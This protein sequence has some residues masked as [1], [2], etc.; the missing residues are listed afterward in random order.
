[1]KNLKNVFSKVMA[2]LLCGVM[3]LGL[4]PGSAL[5]AGAAGTPDTDWYTGDPSAAEFT[6]TTADELAGLA[7]LV[8][9]RISFTG[10][11][12]TLGA[13]IDLSDY[14]EGYNDG[15]GWVP[16]GTYSTQYGNINFTGTF[17]GGG[18]IITGLYIDT[19]VE[20]A[21]LF[22]YL[23]GTVKRLGI[24]NA[25]VKGTADY[26]GGLA[27]MVSGATVNNCYVTG[28]VTGTRSTGGLI[29][30]IQSTCQIRHSY[31]ACT[32]TGTDY[33]G[34]IAGIIEFISVGTF[35]YISNCYTLGT[36]SGD[37]TVGGIV[38]WVYHGSSIGY[39]EVAN[40]VAL[41]QS[42]SGTT[43]VGRIAGQG[44]QLAENTAFPG[45]T[46][47]GTAAV[48]ALLQ[49]TDLSA[50][51]ICNDASIGG[52]FTAAAGW[53]IVDG[54]LPGFGAGVE[55][56]DF[57]SE[58]VPTVTDVAVSPSSVNLFK[59]ATQQFAAAV[60]GTNDPDQSVTWSVSGNNNAGTVI[61][62]AG[63]LTVPLSETASTLTVTAT[64]TFDTTKFGTAAVLLQNP[65][66]VVTG[67]TVSPASVSVQRGGMRIFTATVAGQFS[68]SQFVTWR[69]TGNNSVGTVMIGGTLFIAANETAAR[70]TVRA[71]STANTG[72]FGTASVTVTGTG[73][74]TPPPVP[75]TAGR[76]TPATNRIRVNRNLTLR[77][78][79]QPGRGRVRSVRWS[80]NNG[81]ARIVRTRSNH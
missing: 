58:G 78:G 42:V 62:A 46:V 16:I 31:A 27:G 77:A 4:M 3:A 49:G 51:V 6:I 24:V 66:P 20:Y 68:P 11:T 25:N 67:V 65:P 61:S 45:M 8:N 50:A 53:T 80:V 22:R 57:I 75:S 5:P 9:A 36:V 54:M 7:Q 74:T 2:L 26:T 17:D 60:T 81:R 69:V 39:G 14:G 79:A 64:S 70:L 37:N 63:I 56:P 15:K 33:V 72:R 44:S 35:S 1:M 55:I 59:G 19:D 76:I 34:G 38:G 10:K 48:G 21:G 30:R 28:S 41:N 73:T 40:N 29:G 18:H 12:V 23:A 13:D 43:A 47:N 52:R 32:V 71:T